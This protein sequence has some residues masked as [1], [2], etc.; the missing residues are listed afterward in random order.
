MQKDAAGTRE[1]TID[2]SRSGNAPDAVVRRLP[3]LAQRA[4]NPETGARY[5]PGTG[6]M[7]QTHNLSNQSS[8]GN[9]VNGGGPPSD[10]GMPP[11]RDVLN[12]ANFGLLPEEKRDFRSFGVSIGVNITIAVV[13]ILLAL[14]GVHQVQV[15]KQETLT[16]LTPQPK[17]YVPP[18]PPVIHMPPVPKLNVEPPKIQ[19]PV[20][21]PVVEPPKVHIEVAMKAPVMPAPTPRPVV[22]PPKP[23]LGAFAAAHEPAHQATQV[24]HVQT[25]GFGQPTGA[26]PA[27][28]RASNM[29]VMGGFGAAANSNRGADSRLGQV[30]SAG[31]GSG[32]PAGSP[33]GGA[34]GV[35][36]TAGFG[37]GTRQAGSPGGH[38]TIASGGFGAEQPAHGVQM[39]RAATAQ[40][41]PIVILSKPLP[42]YTAEARA[43][44]IQGDVT[45]EVRFTADGRVEVLRVVRGLGHGLDEQAEQAA[46]RIRFKPATRDGKAVD[47]VSIIRIT[48]EL[49]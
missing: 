14:E 16:F 42:Q 19:P 47:Q 31:F 20:P 25:A 9:G 39:A 17:P 32:A 2:E 11:V 29:P 43:A 22:A 30:A 7:P 1:E 45:L 13:L 44:R 24:A 36:S 49:A 26:H 28:S 23:V 27:D 40:T 34:H 5:A 41:T 35:V 48:F 8:A 33:R 46:S 12:H 4:E 38:G 6:S 37:S 21:K 3:A 15:H 18:P 10:S